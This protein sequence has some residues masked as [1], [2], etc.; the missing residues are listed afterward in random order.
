MKTKIADLN[1]KLMAFHRRLLALELKE[2]EKHLGK[3]LSPLEF[4]QVLTTDQKFSWLRPFTSVLA[5]IDA[6]I[7]DAETVTDADLARIKN[8]VQS[9]LQSS[10]TNPEVATRL[11]NYH[12]LDSEFLTLLLQLKKTLSEFPIQH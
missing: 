6:F 12:S 1:K 9:L 10:E 3:K 8:K 7:D 4:L 2:A 11:Q 5:E